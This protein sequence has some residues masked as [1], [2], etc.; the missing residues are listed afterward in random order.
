[1]EENC[2]VSLDGTDF[3]IQEPQIFDRKWCSHKFKGP[4][5][6]YEIGLCIKTGEIVW[7]YGG[8]PCGAWPDLKLA[9]DL[10]LHSINLGEK[11][12]ADDGYGDRDYFIYPR[13]YPHINRYLKKVMSRHETI[14]HRIRQFFVL[15]GIFRHDLSLHPICFHAV[16]NLTQLS[17]ESGEYLY[18]I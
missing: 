18:M 13:A 16:I 2:F 9:R 15:H 3:R 14:N 11:T 1:M 17:I 10:Y 4:G 5:V 8:F 7:A 12:I 6:R